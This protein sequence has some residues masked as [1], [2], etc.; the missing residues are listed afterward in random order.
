VR[1]CGEAVVVVLQ[2]ECFFSEVRVITFITKKYSTLKTTTTTDY[3]ILNLP[4]P[5]V[6][7]KEADQIFFSTL[8]YTDQPTQ[9]TAPPPVA[10][11]PFQPLPFLISSEGDSPLPFPDSGIVLCGS[12][13]HKS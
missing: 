13:V 3:H 10:C 9:K 4:P 1:G 12:V 7:V 2:E 8:L 6:P 11:L 5:A